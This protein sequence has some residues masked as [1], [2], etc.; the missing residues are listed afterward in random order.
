MAAQ[1]LVPGAASDTDAARDL[2]AG[3]N[4]AAV[5]QQGWLY[6][7][8]GLPLIVRLLEPPDVSVRTLRVLG[9]HEDLL[10]AARWPDLVAT[11]HEG[12]A[13]HRLQVRSTLPP[14][15]LETLGLRVFQHFI[16][17]D[18]GV[19][20][21]EGVEVL[22]ATWPRDHDYVADLMCTSLRNG[23]PQA[24][25]SQEQ[26]D[27]YVR[28]YLRLGQPRGCDAVIAYV[29]GERAGTAVFRVE[30]DE[31][32]AEPITRLVDIM[33]SERGRGHGWRIAPAFES[34]VARTPR[35]SDRIVGTVVG[36]EDGSDRVTLERLS[37]A[38]WSLHHTWWTAAD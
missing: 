1:S 3:A 23:M 35:L 24:D 29:D 34:H 20:E 13:A 17:K 28:G 15:R 9:S 36:E 22:P 27:L 37:G 26:L 11:L 6:R 21:V 33:T 38:G 30:D 4:A 31:L 14:E 25:F 18:A 5:V 19:T 2:G 10:T 8:G 16:A 7:A 32:T 12:F